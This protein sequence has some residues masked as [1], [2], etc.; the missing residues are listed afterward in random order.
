VQPDGTT[1]AENVTAPEN[2]LIL[3]TVQVEVPATVARVVIGAQAIEKSWIV[4]ITL[5]ALERAPLAA[6]TGTVNGAT[7][8]PLAQVTDRTAPENE[9][10][11]PP[12]KTK[13]VGTVHVTAPENP[14]I[15]VTVQ[16]EEPA[17]VARVVIPGQAGV[18][19]WMVTETVV[20]LDS[21]AGATPVVPV[22]GTLNTATPLAQ[23]TDRTAPVNEPEQP[24]G[25][26]KPALTANV[27]APVNPLMF[28]TAIVE[29]PA[30]VA[31]AV[32]AGPA[33]EKSTTWNVTAGVEV[34]ISVPLV[35][36]TVAV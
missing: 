30:T 31:R 17:T 28:V 11:Q 32:I 12:G 21:V 6:V 7:P 34:R 27:T 8:T 2:P 13:L 26:T 10:E 1:P 33:I 5:P 22:T 25:K 35:P 15:G 23:V 36:V 19:S 29:V 18:K 20:D 3:V 24:P 9:P 4:T 16:V 14:L